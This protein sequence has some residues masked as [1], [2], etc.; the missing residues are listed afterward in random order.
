LVQI[1][2]LR[3]DLSRVVG[4]DRAA[5]YRE[6]LGL[7]RLGW[8]T[9]DVAHQPIIKIAHVAGPNRF[10]IRDDWAGASIYELTVD[11]P[12]RAALS[13]VVR[14]YKYNDVGVGYIYRQ[15][16]SSA[17]GQRVDP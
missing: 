5:A 3:P 16:G 8:E 11:L 7:S 15:A 6:P 13:S 12:E 9:C 4:W 1:L 2:G 10:Y 17:E 14:T